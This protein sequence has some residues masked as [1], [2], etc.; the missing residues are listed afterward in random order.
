MK[1]IEERA[2]E[3][4]DKHKREIYSWDDLF[5]YRATQQAQL[6]AYTKGA[7]DQ[8]TID[9]DK[10]CKWFADYLME[11]GYLDDWMRNSSNMLSGE[12]RFRKAMEE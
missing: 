11:I 7:E 4:A 5:Q 2:K 1:S 3:Y 8:K 10:A 6:A 12:E 9:I